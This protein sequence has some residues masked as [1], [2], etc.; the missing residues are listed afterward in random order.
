MQHP[1]YVVGKSTPV[2]VGDL[3]VGD[4]FWNLSNNIYVLQHVKPLTWSS[5]AYNLTVDDF[6]TYFVDHGIWVSSEQ[7]P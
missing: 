4:L 3:I 2:R 7:Q 5:L 6:H 1:F